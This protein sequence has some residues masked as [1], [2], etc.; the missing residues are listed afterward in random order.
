MPNSPNRLSRFWQELRRRKVLPFLIGYVAA[1]LA[2]IEFFDITQDNFSIP[3]NTLK[4]IY[5]L[6]AIGLP[7]VIILPW[8]INRRNLKTISAESVTKENV[9]QEEEKKSNNNLPVQLTNFIGRNKEMATVK[10]LI[11]EHRLVTL[12]G[13]GGCGKTRLACE[14]AAQLVTDFE[15]GVWF[16]DLA[17]VSNENRVAREISETLTITE[18]ADK[19][20]IDTIIERI[21]EQKLLIILD[22]CEHLIKTC[23]KISGQLIQSTSKLKILATSRE[24]LGITGEQVWRVPSLT[25]LDPKVIIDLKSVKESEA[26][27]LFN[28]RAKLNNPEFTLEVENVT[29]VV[30]ICNKVDGIPLAVE[31]VASRTRHMDPKTILERFA[32]R[33][34]R[35]TTSDPRIS[36]RQQTLKATIDWSYNLLSD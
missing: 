18:V 4:L 15:D 13:A 24:S 10:S 3:Y 20:L 22:N 27:M 34:Q 19:S 35:I 8:I 29:E 9:S 16:V 21:K 11:E 14:V 25:L 31:L 6:A 26:V 28:D 30:T 2:I 7:I 32:D 36:K 17:P 1:C 5:L 23:A 12:T 33:L